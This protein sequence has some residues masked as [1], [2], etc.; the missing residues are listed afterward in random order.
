MGQRPLARASRA[1]MP[2]LAA[3]AIVAYAR[4]LEGGPSIY[5]ERG[6]ILV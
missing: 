5:E 4:A 6:L 2:L 1:G 3:A